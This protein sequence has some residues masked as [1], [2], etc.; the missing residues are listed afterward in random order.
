MNI[1][2]KLTGCLLL[3]FVSTPALALVTE[4]PPLRGDEV[5][6][7]EFADSILG[8]GVYYEYTAKAWQK[9]QNVPKE[10]IETVSHNS[11]TLLE[12]ADLLY[13]SAGIS[14]VVKREALMKSAQSR[15]KERQD[16]GGNVKDFI[17]AYGQK[18]RLLMMQ[19]PSK[20]T[21]ITNFLERH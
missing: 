18:C 7:I 11:R 14:T 21:E 1:A 15:I 13:R 8:C 19:Y 3:I 2:T 6:V 16:S 17:Y 12:T 5:K 9:N 10:T 4:S 20:L